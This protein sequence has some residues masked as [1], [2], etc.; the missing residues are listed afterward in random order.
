MAIIA[1]IG[2]TAGVFLLGAMVGAA[3]RPAARACHSAAPTAAGVVVWGGAQACGVGVLSDSVLWRWDGVRWQALPGPPIPPREDA[4]L[5][6]FGDDLVLIGGRR[7][8][9]VASDLWRFDGARWRRVDAAGGPGP[10]EH[11]AVAYDPV[12]RRVVVFGGAVG[13]TFDAKTYEFDG[14]RWSA[15]DVAGPAPRVGHGMAWSAADGG[16]LLYGG[17]REDS[18]RDL[19]RWDGRRWERLAADGPT[20]TEGHVVAEAADGILIVGPGLDGGGAVRAWQWRQGA[21]HPFGP[22]GPPLLIGATA[23]FDRGRGAL[24]LWG[25]RAEGGPP[26]D[27]IHELGAQGWRRI[28]PTP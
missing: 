25:G 16:V 17:F 14:T 20:P 3:Q 7:D 4:L 15:F 18:F 21:F 6:P 8:G 19:W 12:R 11:G 9:Q 26:S 10:I 22:A 1:M 23:T 28:E 24:V 5:A 2:R 27:A 13:R